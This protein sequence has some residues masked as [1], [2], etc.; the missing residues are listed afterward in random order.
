MR[1][2]VSLSGSSIVGANFHVLVLAPSDVAKE[3]PRVH[4]NQVKV[5][6]NVHTVDA[7]SAFVEEFR[8]QGGSARNLDMAVRDPEAREYVKERAL[9]FYTRQMTDVKQILT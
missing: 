9:S 2:Q 5:A 8:K 4:I 3:L 1:E 6:E 7:V